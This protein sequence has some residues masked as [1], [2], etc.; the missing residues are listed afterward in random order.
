MPLACEARL[1]TL[2]ALSAQTAQRLSGGCPGALLQGADAVEHHRA[3]PAVRVHMEVPQPLQLEPVK[4]EM[5]RGLV[6]TS[7]TSATLEERAGVAWNAPPR[8]S[9]DLLIALVGCELQADLSPGLA[10][11]TGGLARAPGTSCVQDPH[12]QRSGHRQQVTPHADVLADAAAVRW[13]IQQQ[14]RCRSSN[15]SKGTRI[16]QIESHFYCRSTAAPQGCW[17]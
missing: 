4:A 17:G 15:S 12:A 11:A 9:S 5:S 13:S 3:R 14:H 6:W 8:P 10:S 1:T 16:W 2:S 7:Y